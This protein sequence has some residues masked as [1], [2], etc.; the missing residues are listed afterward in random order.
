MRWA[1]WGS[2]PQPADPTDAQ[3][4]EAENV[5]ELYPQAAGHYDDVERPHAEVVP[6]FARGTSAR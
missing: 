5:V 6:L 2:N 3:V 1:P 4:S